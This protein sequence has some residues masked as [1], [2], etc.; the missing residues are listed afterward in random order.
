MKSVTTLL[1]DALRA[2][3]RVHGS[4]LRLAVLLLLLHR[5][6]RPLVVRW[7]LRLHYRLTAQTPELQYQPTIENQTL[8]ARC[9]SIIKHKYYAPWYLFN[10]HLQTLYLAQAEAWVDPIVKYERQTLDMPDGGILS[11][12]WALPPRPDCTVPRV[13]DLDPT[14]RTMLILPGLTGGSHEYYVRCLVHRMVREHG[15]QAVVLNARGCGDTP[16]KTPRLFSIAATDDLRFVL[17]HLHTK[18]AFQSDALVLVGFSMGS[19]VMVKFLGEEGEHAKSLVTAAVSVGNP[20]D[21]EESSRHIASTALYRNT[22]YTVLTT[23]LLK[24]FFHRSNAHQVFKGDSVIDLKALRNAKSVAEFD[25]RLTCITFKYRDVQHYYSDAS[26]NQYIGRVRVPLLCLSAKDDPICVAQTIPYAAAATNP[27]VILCVTKSG[28]HLGFFEGETDESATSASTSSSDVRVWSVDAIAEFAESVRVHQPSHNTSTTPPLHLFNGHLQTLQLTR[29]EARRDPVVKYE[30]QTLDMPD[31]GIL[32]LDW[33]LPPRPNRS[34]PRVSEL[35]CTRRT[36]LVIPGLTGGSGDFYVRCQVHHMVKELGWQVVVMNARGCADTP[37]KTPQFYCA[38]YTDDLRFVIQY[39]E[40][41]Y[42]FHADGD[43][44]VAVGFSMGGNILVKYLGEETRQPTAP[45]RLLTA[46]VSVGN[47]WNL[48][49]CSRK[50]TSTLF[51]RLTYN[52]ALG[53]N[54]K[55]LFF[56]LSNAH[57]IFQ[58]HPELDHDA[59][60]AADSIGDYDSHVTCRLFGYADPQAYYHDASSAHYLVDV[61]LPLLC[62]NATDDPISTKSAIP[63]DEA[64]QNPQVILVTTERGGHLAFY[65]ETPDHKPRVW[66]VRAVAEYAQTHRHKE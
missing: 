10:G 25:E 50:V 46:A 38:A 39:L 37:V 59:A 42:R 57:E 43:A 49:E 53:H 20:Y 22:Y 6:W 17:S 11:L 60:R 30:R 66:S 47:P 27:H 65:E 7:A 63:T 9:A 24:L 62:L 14:R 13:S 35:D 51:R 55:R 40:T 41:T 19:N 29:D 26:S 5:A 64:M 8:L 58:D 54:S 21:I 33:A 45:H 52:K 32:S 1:L 34:I 36:M 31:G 4:R 61:R 15:W 3:Y 18:Y 48:A 23:N 16:I 12:D 56:D 44:F 2:F 28:G